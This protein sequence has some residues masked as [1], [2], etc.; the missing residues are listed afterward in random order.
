MRKKMTEAKISYHQRSKES[1]TTNNI[2]NSSTD[3]IIS[4]LKKNKEFCRES[5]NISNTA[6]K[7]EE[8]YSA[9]KNQ[10]EEKEYLKPALKKAFK[11]FLLS[12]VGITILGFIH[13]FGGSFLGLITLFEFIGIKKVII[14]ATILGFFIGRNNVLK[15]KKEAIDKLPEYEQKVNNANK[16]L[17]DYW[18]KNYER[19]GEVKKVIGPKYF[20]EEA[21]EHFIDYLENGRCFSLQ[22][23]KNLYEQELV[24]QQLIDTQNTIKERVEKSIFLAEEAYRKAEYAMYAAASA[25]SDAKKANR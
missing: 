18:F 9:I 3:R 19:L 21:I 24:N 16:Q 10:A 5:T 11:Y 22:E 12:V 23:A 25:S 20:T 2:Y 1:A 14:I 7:I 15:K 6:L 8:E 17:D 4:F 13:M